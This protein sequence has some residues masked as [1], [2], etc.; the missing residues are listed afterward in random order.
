MRNWLIEKIHSLDFIVNETIVT[1]NDLLKA[2]EVFLSNS[3]YNIRWVKSIE[4]TFYTNEV[5]FKIVSALQIKE[6]NVFC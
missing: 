3:I 6:E 2:D 4:E 1:K 5:V